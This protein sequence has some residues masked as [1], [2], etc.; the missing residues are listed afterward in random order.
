MPDCD[1]IIDAQ[2]IRY[3]YSGAE[4]MVVQL[5]EGKKKKA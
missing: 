4:L 2:R 3:G 5:V 1:Y